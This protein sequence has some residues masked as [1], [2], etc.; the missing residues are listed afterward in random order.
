[1]RQRKRVLAAVLSFLMLFGTDN[2]MN[3]Y[4]SEIT[5]ENLGS[6]MQSVG[7]T[8]TETQ[9][10][11]ETQ[12][13][14]NVQENTEVSEDTNVQ[15]DTEISESIRVQEDTEGSESTEVQDDTKEQPDIREQESTD[16]QKDTKESKSVQ[17]ADDVK[18]ELKISYLVL[19]KAQVQTPDSQFVLVGYEAAD[20]EITGMTLRY[21]NR[22]TGEAYEETAGELE[23]DA[24][25]FS[26]EVPKEQP[27]GI[28]D[29]TG[30]TKYLWHSL[31]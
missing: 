17:L 4:A 20:A 18:Q 9:E 3:I 1:M 19:Q 24:A 2:S 28:Y 12:K 31:F 27:K 22:E 30:I 23:E 16:V 21:Q 15:E 13:E 10:E 7:E 26:M 5:G 25:L 8:E 14:T 6:P 11:A 29:L